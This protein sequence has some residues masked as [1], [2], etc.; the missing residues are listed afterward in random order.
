MVHC[1]IKWVTYILISEQNCSFSLKIIFVLA[2]S[3][4]PDEMPH[5]AAFNRDLLCLQSLLQ[6][7]YAFIPRL[8]E[9][10]HYV[11]KKF[12]TNKDIVH[13]QDFVVVVVA[14]LFRE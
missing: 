3:I 9:R 5:Y 8:T 13:S 2:N 11:K 12:K 14:F 7:K 1:I 10:N 6:I 4:V